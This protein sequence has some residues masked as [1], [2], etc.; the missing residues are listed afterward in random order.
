MNNNFKVKIV[1]KIDDTLKYLSHLDIVRM[2]Y[3][4]IRRTYLPVRYT[5]GYSPK[6]KI[7]FS[8]ATKVG[9]SNEENSIYL[10]LTE[11]L[12][13]DY[14]LKCI[15]EKIHPKIYLKESKYEGNSN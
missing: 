14:I 13:E 12:N 11:Q 15:K 2:F 3:R 5:E 8:R 9:H 10:Y 1:Y 6:I 7:S 4:T